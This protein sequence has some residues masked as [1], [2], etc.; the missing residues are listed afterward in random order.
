MKRQ[1]RG[2][3]ES[4]IQGIYFSSFELKIS[5]TKDALIIPVGIATTPIPTNEIIEAKTFPKE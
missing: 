4:N 2:N 5:V 3:K 1:G